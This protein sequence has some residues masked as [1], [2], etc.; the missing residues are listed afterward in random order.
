MQPS[1]A[2]DCGNEGN[3]AHGG[4]KIDGRLSFA[5]F[6]SPTR[7]INAA[8]EKYEVFQRFYDQRVWFCKSAKKFMSSI[9]LKACPP[10]QSPQTYSY[11]KDLHL[12][13]YASESLYRGSK[14]GFSSLLPYY[15]CRESYLVHPF[16][17]N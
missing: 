9:H 8:K 14:G 6:S 13:Q 3:P 17:Q 15:E 16:Q 10:N 5:Y 12:Y 1:E 11:T 4:I 7:G 2:N